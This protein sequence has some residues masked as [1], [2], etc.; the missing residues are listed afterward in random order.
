MGLPGVLVQPLPTYLAQFTR[1]QQ[2]APRFAK[3]DLKII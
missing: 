1:S 3:T 2:Q